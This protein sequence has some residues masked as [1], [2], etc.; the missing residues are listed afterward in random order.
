MSDNIINLEI[1]QQIEN[2][3]LSIPHEPIPETVEQEKHEI[4]ETPKIEIPKRKP[5]KDELVTKILE[6]N[7]AAGKEIQAYKLRRMKLKDLE[8]M[9]GEHTEKI[10]K[11]NLSKELLNNLQD[12]AK[13]PQI[14]NDVLENAGVQGL[15]NMNLLVCALLEITSIKFEEKL[16]GATLEGWAKDIETNKKDELKAILKAIY[17]QHREV[18]DK[19]CSPV[20]IWGMFM[21]MSGAS[22]VKE[23]FKK[24]QTAKSNEV[25]A[26]SE[27]QSDQNLKKQEPTLTK[28]LRKNLV[29]Q[30]GKSII[31]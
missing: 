15:Y 2:E 17:Q 11:E 14:G 22:I 28:E 6:L 21:M 12:K 1:I 5:R 16:H 7:K 10:V 27:K 23:N 9:L 26:Q 8:K 3:I 24:K 20:A 4:I 29:P 30:D 31:K 19:Y 25:P 13:L 18:V